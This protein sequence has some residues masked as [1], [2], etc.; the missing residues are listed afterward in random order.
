MAEISVECYSGLHKG[1]DGMKQFCELTEKEFDEF[2]RSYRPTSFLQSVPMG[3]SQAERGYRVYYYGLKDGDK[4]IAAGLFTVH[5]YRRFFKIMTASGGML[6]DYEN[7]EDLKLLREGFIHTFGKMGIAQVQFLPSFKLIE[8]DIDGRI[9]EGGCDNHRLVDNLLAAGFHHHGYHNHYAT[10]DIRW[11]FHKDLRGIRDG[12][13][14]LES[15]GGQNRWAT[16]KTLKLGI[17]VRDLG[18]DELEQFNRILEHTAER[19]DFSNRG[20]EYYR[21]IYHHFSG[22]G[23]V[24]FLVAEL[25]L[26]VYEEKL[27]AMREEQVRE[28]AEAT[29]RHASKPTKKMENR[30]NVAQEAIDGFD[31]KLRELEKDLRPKGKVIPL[32]AAVFLRYADTITYLFSGAYDEYLHFNAP[33]AIQWEAMNWALESGIETY[34]FYGTAGEYAGYP[35]EGVYHFKKGFG[36]VVVEKPGTFSVNPNPFLYRILKLISDID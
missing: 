10:N 32:A 25:D 12:D 19:R 7:M 35:D 20:I 34:D 17:R 21:S 2:S 8:H 4:V 27:R 33:Y 18:E 11:F 3:R 31:E 30:M 13:A 1:A 26:D 9:V 23:D 36:G 22:T 14:L 24:R 6:M 15:F 16:R 29:A 5:P 28:L